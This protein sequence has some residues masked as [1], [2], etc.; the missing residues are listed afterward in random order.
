M[1]F[2]HLC[3]T[4][5]L[6]SSLF[7]PYLAGIG[8]SHFKGREPRGKADRGRRERGEQDRGR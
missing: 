5:F 6:G 1:T 8:F 2:R 3:P 4:L 7:F